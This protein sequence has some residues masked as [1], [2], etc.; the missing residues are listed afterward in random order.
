MKKLLALVLVLAMAFTFAACGVGDGNVSFA[1]IS[2]AESSEES[3][4]PVDETEAATAALENALK[5]TIEIDYEAIEKYYDE[6]FVTKE[7]MEYLGEAGKIVELFI[8]KAQ[9]RV[10][11]C[12]LTEPEKATATVAVSAVD[13]GK[14]VDELTPKMMEKMQGKDMQNISPEEML[15]IQKESFQ[16]L[17]EALEGEIDFSVETIKM[18]LKKIDGEWKVSDYEELYDAII[19]ALETAI[20]YMA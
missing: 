15:E 10:S 5:A 4:E 6:P 16:L 14:L 1:E 18:E 3:K 11:A 12:K 20:S 7:G 19:G 17:E 2:S 13:F 9:T 8:K